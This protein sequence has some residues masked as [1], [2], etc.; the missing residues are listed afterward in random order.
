MSE[1]SKP[2]D[3]AGQEAAKGK[4]P[5]AELA[6]DSGSESDE[7]PAET[8]DPAT[9][10]KKK[11]NKKKKKKAKDAGV[12]SSEGSG[13]KALDGLTMQQINEFMALN[14][15]LK[16]EIEDQVAA[17]SSSGTAEPEAVLEAL[18]QLRLQDIMTGLASSGKNRKDMASYKFWSTQPVQQFVE[19]AK[20]EVIEE[21]PIKVQTIDEIP[22]EPPQLALDGFRW[23]QVDLNDEKEM[24]EVY[25]LLNGHYVEDNESLFRFNY[26]PSL[27]KWA[28]MSPGWKKQWHVGIR[29]GETLCAFISA[30]PTE[31]RMRNNVL[32]CSEVNFLCVHKKL[33]SKR[34]TPVLIKEITRLCNR[35]GI[36]QAIY[37]AGIVLP[38]PVSTCRY[39]HR[40]LNWQKL[41][42]VRFSPC[43]PNSKPAYQ[44]RKY[45]VPSNTS[46]QGLRE[47]EAKDIDAVGSLLKRYLDRFD[48]APVFTREEIDHWLLDKKDPAGEQVV[49]SYVV[50]NKD[51]KITDFFSFYCLESSVINHPKHNVVRAAYLFYYASEHGLTTPFDKAGLK[52]RLNELVMDALILA[53][54]NN[55]DVFNALS[56]LDNGLFLEEQ[57]FGAGDGQLHYYLFNYKSNPIHGGVDKNN[58][59]DSNNLSG[60]GFVAL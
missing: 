13:Q 43:P 11:K 35:E 37:T 28:L 25:K 57:K 1:E 54:Q 31:I 41:Y 53:K 46:T 39:F 27:L 60:V 48:I 58:R 38:R 34:L 56:I 50:E 42:E 21:G 36:F 15:A 59:I 23:V 32:H 44:V 55:F 29:V 6:L 10:S 12:G 3:P 24:Q 22:A 45:A 19:A 2:V 47:M 14:P 7:A 18:K 9:T 17:E 40:A 8:A 49:W 4:Q 20:P 16:K 30:I 26:S 52:T 33:R 5:A 51:G